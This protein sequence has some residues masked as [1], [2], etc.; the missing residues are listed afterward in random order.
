MIRRNLTTQFTS[1]RAAASGHKNTFLGNITHN[2]LN[3]H[4]HSFPAKKIFNLN[5]TNHGQIQVS[6]HKLINTGKNFQVTVR[7]FTNIHDFFCGFFAYTRHGDDNFIDIIFFHRFNNLIP[8]ADN[9]HSMN[10]IILLMFIIVDKTFDPG[11]QIITHDQLFHDHI[12]GLTSANDHCI[13]GMP[14]MIPTLDQRPYND[15]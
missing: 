11:I 13:P 7:I 3:I 1:D 12:S 6:G 8:A 5:I 9:F 2:G 14:S 10:I 15:G 4:I